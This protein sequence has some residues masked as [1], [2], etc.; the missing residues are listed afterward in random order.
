MKK[1]KTPKAIGIAVETELNLLAASSHFVR[2]KNP[3]KDCTHN[4]ESIC[5]ECVY[6]DEQNYFQS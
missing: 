5:K 1:Y 4:G 2:C 6:R 3:C